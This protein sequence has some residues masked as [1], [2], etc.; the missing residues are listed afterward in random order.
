MKL[1]FTHRIKRSFEL[2]IPLIIPP[3]SK[4]PY[5]CH[6]QF[7][8]YRI[9]CPVCIELLGLP[10]RGSVPITWVT[11]SS[12][13]GNRCRVDII[14]G[15]DPLQAF[16]LFSV[17]NVPS[18]AIHPSGIK[19]EEEYVAIERGVVGRLVKAIRQFCVV[20]GT[21]QVQ[22]GRWINKPDRDPDDDAPWSYCSKEILLQGE[23]VQTTLPRTDFNLRYYIT[24][25]WV[26]GTP[27]Y[28]AK[29]EI[30]AIAPNGI[31]FPEDLLPV[32]RKA[33][34][35]F[36][37]G[38]CQAAKV[39]PVSIRLDML[40]ESYQVE[41]RGRGMAAEY[42]RRAFAMAD[43]VDRHT[44][45]FPKL[46]RESLVGSLCAC[47]G[48]P[49]NDNTIAALLNGLYGR[50]SLMRTDRP[51][52]YTW[53][54]PTPMMRRLRKF[55][56]RRLREFSGE[57]IQTPFNF[58]FTWAQ[59]SSQDNYDTG[60]PSWSPFAGMRMVI[61]RTVRSGIGA[62]TGTDDEYDNESGDDQ[63]ENTDSVTAE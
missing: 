6:C 9:L 42:I 46:R 1:T 29:F 44:E 11:V 55:T 30:I 20:P 61:T 7:H 10:V 62:V 51:F 45:G 25:Y 34:S 39:D 37:L 31:W 26:A 32:I 17:L 16:D 43:S 18:T 33:M 28:P 53:I 56:S 24:V 22:E 23:L 4:R 47:A 8:P 63:D 57:I 41:E 60:F 58:S 59:N 36:L 3:P 19:A 38:M 14:G 15:T 27:K 13:A 50:L 5:K 35:Q 21:N 2:S 54:P 48:R 40:G 52:Q 49:L 12:R